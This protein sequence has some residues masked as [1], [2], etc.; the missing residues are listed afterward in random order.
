MVS[1]PILF[2]NL[3]SIV[4]MLIVIVTIWNIRDQNGAK[5]LFVASLFMLLWSIGSFSDLISS[6]MHVKVIWRNF[7]QIGVFFTPVASLLF[8][9][10][11]TGIGNSKR[12]LIAYL[13]YTFQSIGIL[14]VWTDGYHH[15][16]RES[17][18]VLKTPL[19]ES[20][21]IMPTLLAKFL[22]SF[23]ILF[24][25]IALG[26][27]G[28]YALRTT[29]VSRKQSMIVFSGMMVGTF[30][31][32]LKVIMTDTFAKL[33]P[34]S[35]MFAVSALF[36][37][38]GIYRYD[39]LKLSPL[40]REL[41]FHFLGDGIVIASTHGKLLEANQAALSMMGPTLSDLSTTLVTEL[42]Q[43]YEFVNQGKEGEFSF[44]H[45]DTYYDC[46]V[47]AIKTRRGVVIG[48][49]SLLKDNTEQKRKSDLLQIRAEHDGLTGIYNRRTFIEKVEKRLLKEGQK[50]SLVFFDIDHFKLINDK[51]GHMVGDQML[52]AV[53]AC[54]TRNMVGLDIMGRM[55]GEE[56]AIF[57]AS[58]S[59][60]ETLAWA[61]NLRHQVEETVLQIEGNP[62]SCTISLGLCF[63]STAN[64]DEMYRG[65]DRE[66][67][68]AKES[69]RNCLCHTTLA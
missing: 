5:Q 20:L 27:L 54:A 48:T 21:V 42:P 53:V 19:S 17:I 60:V 26:I 18:T 12:K 41:V 11:Y 63:S 62:V 51:Y 65:A 6:E 25:L 32:L 56:F 24:S 13:S 38:L 22:I 49:I 69:G 31:S 67:Y 66:L 29:T 2:I 45:S 59:K 46:S 36:M 39:L 64:F 9:I 10:V 52:Q 4:M 58:S 7:T 68:K 55:G 1:F 34:I 23:N 15:L 40:A 37:L 57:H 33:V 61:Q 3:L 14:L 47:Y 28:L 43:W 50:N 8:A 44:Y 30:Y 35:G 16:M